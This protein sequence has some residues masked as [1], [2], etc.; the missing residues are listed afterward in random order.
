MFIGRVWFGLSQLQET[1]VGVFQ[2]FCDIS[3]SWT[4]CLAV[5][6]PSLEEELA[7]V[8]L[9]KLQRSRV[10]PRRRKLENHIL[11]AYTQKTLR[12][13]IKSWN[14]LDGKCSVHPYYEVVMRYSCCRL[15]LLRGGAERYV[16]KKQ[17]QSQSESEREWGEIECYFGRSEVWLE[18]RVS[19]NCYDK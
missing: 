8:A 2:F 6:F 7:C 3:L 12:R 9:G 5:W 19:K 18:W 16:I 1:E 4:T 11:V 10:P 14:W 17:S 13:V 15:M